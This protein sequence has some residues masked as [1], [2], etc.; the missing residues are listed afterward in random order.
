MNENSSLKYRFIVFV[1]ALIAW[2][3]TNVV[4]VGVF[5][6]LMGLLIYWDVKSAFHYGLATAIFSFGLTFRAFMLYLNVDDSVRDVFPFAYYLFAGYC[7]GA[8][9][10][11]LRTIIITCYRLDFLMKGLSQPV[12]PDVLIS[13]MTV[14][15][16][17]YVVAII[18]WFFSYRRH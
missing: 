12:I 3:W 11:I 6:F 8:V 15:A 10:V 1:A 17:S 18:V 7:T 14:A 5:T 4:I 9:I 16:L 2:G 13:S